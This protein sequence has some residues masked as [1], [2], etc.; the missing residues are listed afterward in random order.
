MR[1]TIISRSIASWPVWA[2]A[3]LCAVLAGC[4]GCTD[5][6]ADL[7]LGQDRQ[8]LAEPALQATARQFLDGTAERPGAARARPR[9]VIDP[10]VLGPDST[11]P[12]RQDRDRLLGLRLRRDLPLGAAFA[13]ETGVML[14]AGDSRHVLPQGM[15]I[16][17]DPTTIHQRSLTVTPEIALVHRGQAGPFSTRLSLGLGQQ[18]GLVWTEVRSDLLD[19]NN[20]ATLHRP[21]LRLGSAMTDR[22]GRVTLSAEARGYEGRQVEMTVETRWLLGGQALP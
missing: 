10:D 3:I 8:G 19:V 14:A 2:A 5:C 20:R 13:V 9:L 11:T 17:T 21:F 4:A 15:G 6:Q 18:T 1:V 16:L 7:V 22:S 12:H